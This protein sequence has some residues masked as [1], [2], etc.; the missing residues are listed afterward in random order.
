[1]NTKELLKKVRKIEIKTRGLSKQV[2]SG[3][4]HS[5]FKGRG[6]AFSEVRNYIPGDEIRTIDWNVTARFNEPYVKVFE[7]ERELTVMLLI[8][9]SGSE[10]FGSD[11]LLKREFIAEIGAVLAFSA[12]QNNDK[13][14]AILFS[15]QIELYIPPKKGRKHILRI[16]RELIEFKPKSNKTDIGKVVQHFNNLIKKRAIAFLISDFIGKDFENAL[17]ITSKKHDLIALRVFDQRE[18]ELTDLG[19]SL[20]TD[21]ETGKQKWVNTSSK[22]VREI[23][24]NNALS[25]EHKTLEIFKKSKVD[26]ANISVQTGYIQPLMNLFK[27][28]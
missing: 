14:G 22:R 24:R 17:K 3:E 16:I 4:Y 18:K 23:Y 2:F 10:S 25:M 9:I 27:K 13:I 5:A 11:E 1:M 12:T 28:R 6:M 8:D 21:S 7:E 15:D 20:F 26:H 19:L